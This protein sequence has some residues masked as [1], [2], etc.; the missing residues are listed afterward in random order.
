MLVPALLRPIETTKAPYIVYIF[1]LFFRENFSQSSKCQK[2]L[3][4][5]E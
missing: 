2:F 1:Q 4:R 3:R 5:V